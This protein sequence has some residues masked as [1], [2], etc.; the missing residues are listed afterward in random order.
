VPVETV[1]PVVAESVNVI[2]ASGTLSANTELKLSF[3]TGGIL[4]RLYVDTGQSVRAGQLL[5]ELD[6]TELGAGARQM[7]DALQKAER[8]YARAALLFKQDVIAKAQ[9]DDAKTALD[10]A[11]AGSDATNFNADVGR[12]TAAA[13]GTVLRRFVEAGEVMAPGAP[14]LAV[15]Q[16][17]GRKILRV[18]LSDVDAVRV[19]LE[20]RAEVRFDALPG[21]VIPASVVTLAGSANPGTGL[22]D[23]ELALEG[24]TA[25]LSSGVIGQAQI[26]P[27]TN[28]PSTTAPDQGANVELLIPLA[29]L[30]EA[31]EEHAII[32]VIEQEIAQSKQVTL[33]EI[34]G[35]SVIVRDGLTLGE[36]VV[37]RGAPYLDNGMR[38]ISNSV[39]VAV[40][41]NAL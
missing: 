37:I 34:R 13:D 28:A 21:A 14:V 22:F 35:E 5:A 20:D 38:V 7:R 17:S 6:L 36:H 9:L 24:D 39:A 32:Y 27:S 10:V 12:I 23:I 19:N 30:V 8:D 31:N 16:N 1:Q 15:S 4:R 3:K 2:Q 26:T 41:E 18:S 33:G 11:R 29:A 25:R 40:A